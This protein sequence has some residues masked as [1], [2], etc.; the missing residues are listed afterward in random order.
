MRILINVQSFIDDAD[1]LRRKRQKHN[2]SS[3]TILFKHVAETEKR[4]YIC[5]IFHNSTAYGIMVGTSLIIIRTWPNLI[6]DVKKSCY[7][8]IT[9]LIEGVELIIYFHSRSFNLFSA[10]INFAIDV[11]YILFVQKWSIRLYAYETGGLLQW[12]LWSFCTF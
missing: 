4:E 6:W 2:N 7:P 10:V 5:R 3:S 1:S 11:S 9:F 8:Y 12:N